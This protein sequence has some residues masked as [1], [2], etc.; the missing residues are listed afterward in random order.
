M[1]VFEILGGTSQDYYNLIWKMQ[2]LEEKIVFIKPK[3]NNHSN[4]DVDGDNNYFYFDF[5]A[6]SQYY[7]ILSSNF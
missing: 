7:H 5:Y 2:A 6:C 3:L 1:A 4:G